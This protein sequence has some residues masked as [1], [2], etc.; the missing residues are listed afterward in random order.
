MFRYLLHYTLIFFMV[1]IPIQ[2]IGAPSSEIA[3][4]LRQCEKHL[5]ANRLTSGKGGTAFDC[6][7]EVLEKEADNAEALAG[8]QKIEGRYTGW[9]QK[10]FD[11]GQKNKAKRYLES[12]RKVNPKSAKLAE[13]EAQLSPTP[14]TS[15]ATPSQTPPPSDSNAD[16]QA[17]SSDEG[18]SQVS[19][20]DA[21]S[22]AAS[23]EPPPPKK[24]QITDVGQIYELINTTDCLIWPSLD[25][26]EKGGKD[27]WESF[28]PKKGEIGIVLEE[29]KHCHFEN[30]VLI[31]EMDQYYVPISSVG[32][33][34]M[35]EDSATE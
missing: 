34:I 22:Q 3:Q 26:K 4:L 35:S 7:Q 14:S 5:K 2:A 29:M 20:S 24:A 27:G 18:D 32:V 15:S 23:S 8:L 6:Y 16:S 11:R 31:L 12:L 9:A 25:M 19:S 33:Q 17:S 10:A 13:L 30:N 21:A 1:L 28:Y